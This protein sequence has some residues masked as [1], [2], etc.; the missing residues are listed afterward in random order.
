MSYTIIIGAKLQNPYLYTE[1]VKNKNYI[2]ANIKS[3]FAGY[4]NPK[5]NIMK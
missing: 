3:K 4:L 2:N 1:I 5:K